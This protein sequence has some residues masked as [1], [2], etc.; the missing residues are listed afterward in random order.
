MLLL[1]AGVRFV[2]LLLG[3]ILAGDLFDFS[4]LRKGGVPLD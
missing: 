2:E 4:L 1:L 3:S